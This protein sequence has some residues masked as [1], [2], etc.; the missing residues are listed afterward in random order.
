M[1]RFRTAGA[2]PSAL[3]AGALAACSLA[4][5]YAPPRLATPPVAFKEAGPWTLAQPSNAID[6][7]AWWRILGDPTLD[8]L[9]DRVAHSN[10]T[11]AQ[12][13]ARYDEARAYAAE[14][15][16]E[17]Y[18]RIDSGVSVTRNR[19]SNNRPL[20]G[21]N[22]PDLY[23]ADT[24]GGEFGYEIDFWGKARNLAA[25]GRAEATASGDDLAVIRLDLQAELASDYVKLRGLDDQARLLAETGFAYDRALRLTE[26]RHKGGASSGLDVGRAQTQFN[27]TRAEVADVA[28]RR[29][30]YEHAIAAL[31]GEI[32]SNFG[33]AQNGRALS[34]PNP[35]T[36]LPSTLL[37]RRP[38]VAAAERRVFAANAE[39]GVARAAFY[40]NVDL[41]ALGGFQNTGGPGWLTVPESYWT[42]GPAAALTLF[43]GGFRHARLRASRAAYVAAGASYR[44]VVLRAFQEVEDALAAANHLADEAQA[45]AQAVESASR[46][47]TLALA[48]Y[49]QGAANYLE[50]VTAQT[51]ALGA[52]RSA[53]DIQTRRLLAG[54]DLIRAIGGGWGEPAIETGGARPSGGR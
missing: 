29:A 49:R 16:S 48:L 25:A 21:S 4:P 13:V 23:A 36:G 45:Q 42:L 35:P 18:P 3:I 51:A 9:E 6:R 31:V 30:L 39:I 26:V 47:E 34:P 2:P 11:L 37:Q 19:Q 40:P 50:V 32:A 54:I 10:P 53:L 22:Q 20:R 41:T 14:A 28:R 46:T 7:K 24:V 1:M 12:A 8:D 5:T 38:D 52:E 44:A 43:N 17:L 15:A 33:L 27:T